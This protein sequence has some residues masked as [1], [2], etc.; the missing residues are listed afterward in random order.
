MITNALRGT[1]VSLKG[2]HNPL[3]DLAGF[4]GAINLSTAR[5]LLMATHGYEE[6][7]LFDPR[8]GMLDAGATVVV[9]SFAKEPIV[10]VRYD[11]T[12]GKSVPSLR[13]LTPDLLLSEVDVH[14]FDALLLPGGADNPAALRGSSEALD[15]VRRFA[16]E[17]KLIASICHA[18]SL[19]AEAGVIEGR[20]V[21]GW[22][23]IRP[24]LETAGAFV[25]DEPVV[26]DGNLISS[27]MPSD[28]P[29]FTAA[30]LSALARVH[31]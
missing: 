24:R 22:S 7:E 19:L 8:Q 2:L 10:G 26:V 11:R 13:N 12:S 21:T 15:I 31:R 29:A 30:I 23:S 1:P 27:R 17:R 18:S 25:V 16:A 9:A 28:I 3:D 4:D 20:R 5:V 14:S 6:A